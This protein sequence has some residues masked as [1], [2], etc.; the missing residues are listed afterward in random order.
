MMRNSTVILAQ[1]VFLFFRKFWKPFQSIRELSEFYP[2]CAVAALSLH[3][4]IE[5]CIC[6]QNIKDRL[7][8]RVLASVWQIGFLSHFQFGQP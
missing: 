8:K 2:D 5:I 4:P 7:C 3:A 1:G 6:F